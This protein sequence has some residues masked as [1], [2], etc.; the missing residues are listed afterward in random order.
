MA[1]NPDAT[2]SG[3]RMV[4][5]PDGGTIFLAGADAIVVQPVP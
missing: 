1:A 2:A 5:S 4:M 3:V